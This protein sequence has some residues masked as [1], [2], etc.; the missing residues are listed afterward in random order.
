M[1]FYYA[2]ATLS[3]IIITALLVPIFVL[4]IGYG[5]LYKLLLRGVTV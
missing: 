2:F 4:F 1:V 5:V 3:W